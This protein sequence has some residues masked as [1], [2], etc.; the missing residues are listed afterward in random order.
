MEAGTLRKPKAFASAEAADRRG[1]MG[2]RSLRLCP[3]VLTSLQPG[4]PAATHSITPCR[5]PPPPPHGK[6]GA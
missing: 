3:S 4:L 2:A 5:P 6:V 1:R